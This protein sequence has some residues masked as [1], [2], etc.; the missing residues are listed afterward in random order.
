MSR[1]SLCFKIE[2]Q[3]NDVNGVRV[4][5]EMIL[6]DSRTDSRIVWP[7]NNLNTIKF[8]NLKVIFSILLALLV[9]VEEFRRQALLLVLD[10]PRRARLQEDLL[11]ETGL[12]N[13]VWSPIWWCQFVSSSVS[14]ASKITATTRWHSLAR[15]LFS[16]VL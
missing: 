3:I 2:L 8:S 4:L 12:L 10:D 6:T 16:L 15:F 9:F 13:S 11:S 14:S 5:E 1:V 7:A